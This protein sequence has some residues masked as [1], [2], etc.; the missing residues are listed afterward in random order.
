[1]ARQ[2]TDPIVLF[3]YHPNRSKNA[4]LDM[5]V[6]YQGTLVCDGYKVYDSIGKSLQC[7]ISAC[8]AH[9]RRKFWQAEKFAKKE[10]KAGTQIKASEALAFIKK[11]YAIEEK[12][13]GRPPEIIL[14]ARQEH[15]APIL[16]EFFSWL[17]SMESVIL[18]SSPTGKAVRYAL[19][20]WPKFL[21]YS[22][23][24][25]VPIDNNY[26]ENHIRPFVIGRKNWLFSQ[27][28]TG[29]HASAAIYSIVETAKANG[30]DP[31]D[32]LT[33]IF[34]ELPRSLTLEKIESL[35]PYKAQQYYQLKSY[36]L[37]AK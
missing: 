19:D 32:Y 28:P 26:M 6:D 15:S 27:S 11:L 31:F 36:V 13:G 3:K 21:T 35:L 17:Q 1:M 34:K 7:K 10:A 25:K 5:I 16:G 24:G 8:L 37:A 33:L 14:A 23:D 29:A 30:I 20:Q 22:H 4:A 9:I 12:F 18:P 2:G